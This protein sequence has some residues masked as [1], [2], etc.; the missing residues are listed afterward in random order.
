M[1]GLEVRKLVVRSVDADAE[2]EACVAP[3]HDALRAAGGVRG[4]GGV[5]RVGRRRGGMRG[6]E[7]DEVGLVLCVPRGYEAVDLLLLEE[8]L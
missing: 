6:A 7:L 4:A 3:V 8:G 5:G 2:K 1:Y